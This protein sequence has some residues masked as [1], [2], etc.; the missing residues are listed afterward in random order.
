MNPETSFIQA[1][2]RRLKQLPEPPFIYKTAD[3][4][5]NGIPDVLYIGPNGTPLWVEYKIHPNKVTPIQQ[6]MLDTL[7][8]YQQNAAIFTRMNMDSYTTTIKSKHIMRVDEQPWRWIAHQLGYSDA[9]TQ[10]TWAQRRR[11]DGG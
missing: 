9:T 2:H 8:N 4:F 5:T 11:M 10:T 3:R 7:H 1:V 6:V